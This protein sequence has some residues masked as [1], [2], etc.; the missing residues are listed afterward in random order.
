MIYGYLPRYYKRLGATITS[1]G[2]ILFGL[3]VTQ[4]T[5]ALVLIIVARRVLPT[6]YGQY[7]SS[8]GLA[9]LLIVL[10]NAGL[11][12]FLLAR[13][14]ATASGMPLLWRS[15]FRL[16]LRLLLIWIVCIVLAGGLLPDDTFPPAIMYP[17]T[18]GLACDSLTLLSYSALRG[19]DRHKQVTL[20]QVISALAVLGTTLMLPFGPGQIARFSIGRAVVSAVFAVP[21]T[22]LVGKLLHSPERPIP[23]L[24]LVRTARPFMLADLAT[25]IYLKADLT[26][27]SLFLG[28][29]GASIYG[30]A[31]NIVNVSFLVSNALYF[32]IMPIL[33]RTYTTSLR[34]FARIGAAQLAAQALVGIAMLGLMFWSAPVVI[35]LIFGSAYQLSAVVLR[36]LSP[37]L[38]LKS[39]NF[40]LAALLTTANLQSWRTTVQILCAAFNAVANLIVVVPL[41]IVGVA[42]VY[43]L[44]EI[45]L[46]AGYSLVVRKWWIKGV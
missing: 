13:G 17:V 9:S 1:W 41:G 14:S 31:L 4:G 22:A 16:R 15:S 37:I 26:I 19:L 8:Y 29:S 44:S 10:P 42:V 38:L 21:I 28:S 3:A 33:S 39:L 30:P 46:L 25:S 45:F 32:F 36:L 35:D 7:L 24:D 43:V 20:L 12:A 40:G 27:V 5:T 2:V 11:D 34:S 6:E 18:L 23:S